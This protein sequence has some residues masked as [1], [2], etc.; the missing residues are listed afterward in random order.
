MANTNVIK[1]DGSDEIVHEFEYDDIRT[2]SI[3]IVN[4]WQWAVMLRDGQLL[5][6]F[7]AGKYDITTA[8][9]P[10]LTGM[11]NFLMGHKENPYKTKFIFVSK[12]QFQGKWGIRTMVKVAKDYDAT[13]P[14]MANGDFTYRV[15]KAETFITQFVGGSKD[16]SEGAVSMF[17]KNFV[18][19]QVSQ[20]LAHEFYMDVFGNLE[21]NSLKTKTAIEPDFKNR[22]LELLAFKIG[23]VSTEEK[24]QKDIY[25][26]QQFRSAKGTEWKQF[27]VMDRMADAIG[28]SKGGAA[29]GAGML[30]FPQ[31]YQNLNNQAAGGQGQKV[32][33]PYCGGLNSY[34]YK[35]CSN[36]GKPMMAQ[37]QNEAPAQPASGGMK[38]FKKCPYCGEDLSGLPKTPKFCPYCSEQLN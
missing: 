12:K 1:W 7:D 3:L 29:M 19:E 15:T 6:V 5:K 26:F 28:E 18:A 11:K 32:V 4:E 31:M 27:E 30:L 13:V 37:Q 33:C 14:L 36:C 25:D 24:Y 16:V 10:I 38:A 23:N 34:P 20:H 2:L 9:I 35:F 22:G 17:M 8:V 21:N